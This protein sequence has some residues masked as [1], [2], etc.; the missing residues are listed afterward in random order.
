[1]NLFEE[2]T[3]SFPISSSAGIATTKGTLTVTLVPVPE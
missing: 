1:M 3:K 2:G